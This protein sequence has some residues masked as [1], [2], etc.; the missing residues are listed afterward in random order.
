MKNVLLGTALIISIVSGA[1]ELVRA[2]DKADTAGEKALAADLAL[3]QGS[4]ELLHG[5]E[6]KGEP[7]TRSVKTIEGNIETLRR[8]SIKTGKLNHEHSAEFKL[9]KS[10]S[11]H[12][13]TFFAV[14]D[15][16][17]QGLS[18]VY[19]VDKDNFY[20]IP[21]LLHGNDYRNY[22]SHTRIWHWKRVLEKNPN[23]PA[24]N[25]D[26]KSAP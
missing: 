10:G 16:P 14:G 18:Y 9:S 13:F 7:N 4:W 1:T 21:G 20:D 12:V 24:T 2:E 15:S 22:Q 26:T 25:G 19:K 5:N 17:D 6:G 8:Y 3:L 23:E 11:V